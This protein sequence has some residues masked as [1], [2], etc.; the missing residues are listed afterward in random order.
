MRSVGD[1]VMFDNNA[2]LHNKLQGDHEPGESGNSKS[3][4]M[5]RNNVK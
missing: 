4:V 3:L 5:S 2:V 1:F